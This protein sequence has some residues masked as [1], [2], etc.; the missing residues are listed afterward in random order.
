MVIAG[1][2]LGAPPHRRVL[3]HQRAAVPTGGCNANVKADKR[4]SFVLLRGQ[5]C[6][7]FVVIAVADRAIANTAAAVRTNASATKVELRCVIVVA[8]P[9]VALFWARPASEEGAGARSGSGCERRIST[10]KVVERS[11]FVAVL[12]A[13]S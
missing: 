3:E 4:D 8:P 9:S 12:V 10:F 2:R 13:L 6:G 11:L 5:R 1:L 7:C